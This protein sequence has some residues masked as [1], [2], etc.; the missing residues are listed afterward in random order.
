MLFLV[1]LAGFFFQFSTRILKE[2]TKKIQHLKA[3]K[4]GGFKRALTKRGII[5]SMQSVFS[6]SKKN[7]FLFA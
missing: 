4:K 1:I 5:F 2:A 6:A 7:I 3:K